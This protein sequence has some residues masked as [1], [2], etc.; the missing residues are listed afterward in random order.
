QFF[1]PPPWQRRQQCLR[2]VCFSSSS[3]YFEEFSTIHDSFEATMAPP[4][5]DVEG[6]SISEGPSSIVKKKIKKG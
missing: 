5:V 4:T 1:L 6:A 3:T 2:R